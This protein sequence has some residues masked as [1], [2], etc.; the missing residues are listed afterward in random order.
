MKRYAF[1]FFFLTCLPAWAGDG[2]PVIE[3]APWNGHKAATSLTFDDGDHSHL[4]VAIPELD[5]RGM[6]ATF[7]LIANQIDRKDEWRRIIAKGHEIGNHSLDHRHPAEMTPPQ[8]EAQ[9]VGANHVLQKEF[10]VQVRSFAY[11]FTE[12]TP[13][14]QKAL[15][16]TDLLA[17]GGYG[18]DYVLT[19][20]MD[21]DWLDIPA[22]MTETKLPLS[23]YRRW[24][25]EDVKKGGWLVWMIHGL[26]GTVSGWNPILRKNF[27]AILDDIAAKDIWVGTFTEVGSYFMGAKILGK[28]GARTEGNRKTYRWDLPEFFPPHVFLKVRL[29]GEGV[30]FQDGKRLRPDESGLYPVDLDQ[31]SLTLG[32]K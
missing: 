19:P 20:A 8:Q 9:V 25:V 16:K 32:R 15:G 6:K 22:R 1:L 7:F 17:R 12:I 23:T 28:A 31:K 4:D 30:L 14:L 10:G 29:K 24:I 27:T 13:E 26:E 21:P 18:K 2:F 11:P 3:V 5:Q